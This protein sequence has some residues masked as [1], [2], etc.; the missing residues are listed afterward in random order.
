MTVPA[1]WVDAFR[2]FCS[3]LKIDSKETGVGP[4]EFYTSQERYLA[5]IAEGLDRDVPHFI[6]LKSRQLGRQ[7]D[8]HRARHLLGQRQ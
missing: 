8:Q 6:I 4:L 3:F 1:T 7:H 5:E 2:H